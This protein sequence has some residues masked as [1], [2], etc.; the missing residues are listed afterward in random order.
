MNV[1]KILFCSLL[2]ASAIVVAEERV[3]LRGESVVSGSDSPKAEIIVPWRPLAQTGSRG[4]QLKT[5]VAEE[6]QF[7]VPKQFE[8]QV[9][10]S[11]GLDNVK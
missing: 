8:K 1:G 3:D 7:I 6:L 10:V 5:L 2:L 11:Q 9:A 4:L